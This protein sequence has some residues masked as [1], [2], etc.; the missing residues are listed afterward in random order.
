MEEFNLLRNLFDSYVNLSQQEW[1]WYRDLSEIRTFKK[2]E[3][4]T[5]T[6]SL[7]HFLNFIIEG[8]GRSY[9]PAK[10]GKERTIYFGFQGQF[11]SSYASFI[12]Q[13]PSTAS[14]QALSD[15]RVISIH[16]DNLETLYN[17]SKEGEKMGRLSAEEL[18]IM[19]EERETALLTLSAKE[20]FEELL[21]ENPEY[22]LKIPQ[23]HL[24]SYLG[25]TPESFS[26]L[27]KEVYSK[28]DF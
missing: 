19:K 16:K 26:R 8:A 7:E 13:K 2:G 5:Q 3:H 23:K 28:D 15:L 6:G 24:A 11:L 17:H 1:E 12:S 25:I 4:L 27:K 18:Y 9:I 14:I 21:Q 10:D 22:V 20:R